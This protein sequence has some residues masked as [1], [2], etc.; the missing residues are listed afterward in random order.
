M[1]VDSE[2]KTLSLT[3]N[4]IKESRKTPL[5]LSYKLSYASTACVGL[6]PSSPPL[7]ACAAADAD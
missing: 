6:P 5:K 3:F 4:L 2:N 1:H 7:E